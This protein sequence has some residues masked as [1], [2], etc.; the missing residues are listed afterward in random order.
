MCCGRTYLSTGLV[1][2]ARAEARHLVEVFYPF[3]K[4]GISI[5]GL[6]PSCTLALRDEVP[7]LL[8]DE[9]SRIVAEQV[10]TFEEFLLA[11]DAEFSL[12]KAGEKVYVHGHCHQKAFD[13]H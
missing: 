5:V 8:A 13:S 4:Q 6:E 9:K 11:S 3:A 7:A 12:N 2:K 10:Q 1:D